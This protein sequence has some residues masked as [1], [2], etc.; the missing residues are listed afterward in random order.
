[1]CILSK[2]LDLKKSHEKI[3]LLDWIGFGSDTTMQKN[4]RFL[5]DFSQYSSW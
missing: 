4:L 2:I 5:K 3:N 1:M